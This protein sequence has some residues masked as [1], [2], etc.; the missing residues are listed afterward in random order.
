MAVDRARGW[1]ALRAR[2]RR[3]ALTLSVAARRIA[4][5]EWA[6]VA[7][8]VAGALLIAA[9]ASLVAVRIGAWALDETVIKQS[10]VHYTSGLPGTLFHDLNARGTSRLYSLVIAPL[11]AVFDGD[12]AVRAARV[13]N[14]L[15]FTSTAIPIFLLA[16]RAAA[17]R[18][19]SVAAGLL[20]VAAPWLILTTAIY[21]ENAAFPLFLW[22]VWA[23]ERAVRAPSARRDLLT[24][25]GITATTCART[26]FGILLVAYFVCVFAGPFAEARAHGRAAV[27]V[28]PVLWRR[29]I[30][31]HP[32]TLAVL[33]LSVVGLLYFA[34]RGRLH[35]EVQVV[36]G[37][38]SEIQDRT[39]ISSDMSL[40]L[41]VEAVALSIGIGVVPAIVAV[42]W[43]GRALRRGSGEIGLYA[44]VIAVFVVVFGVATVYAQGGYLGVHTE[45]RYYIYA[46]P[47]LWIGALA[48]L[49]QRG[50]VSARGL[51]A[52]G[53]VLALLF[54]TI[55]I[56]PHLDQDSQ[57]LGPV[58]ASMNHLLPQAI[59]HIGIAGLSPRDLL[60]AAGAVA[61]VIVA[62]AWPRATSAGRYVL[63]AAA[64]AVQ[65]GLTFY[66][67]EVARGNIFGVPGRTGGDFAALGWVDRALG[68]GG[69]ASW[70]NS[71]PRPDE[72][73]ADFQQRTVLFY[74]D[75]L[76]RT[77]HVPQLNVPQVNFPLSASPIADGTVDLRSGV[78]ALPPGYAGPVI[79]PTTSPLLQ[80]QGARRAS[81]GDLELVDAPPRA[82][83][84]WAALGLTAEGWV[85][86]AHPARFAAGARAGQRVRLA[87]TF[88]SSP[89]T[90]SGVVVRAGRAE[91]RLSFDAHPAAATVTLHL[92]ACNTSGRSVTGVIRGAGGVKAPT[93]VLAARLSAVRV[94][95]AGAC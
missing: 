22:T 71:Q 76:V 3:R 79:Q 77:V 56:E 9:A 41:L 45:E 81:G 26:Q 19:G 83:V 85:R 31:G 95:A 18:W 65:F 86:D 2:R 1:P 92:D 39:Q 89:G 63:V 10:A 38:Y 93:G 14:T 78:L 43:Y 60:F 42:D 7:A 6:P 52:A 51:W 11:F 69:H 72:F 46:M 80:I 21:T 44:F 20:S 25:V 35:H 33:A 61:A 23:G 57:F 91:R 24:L 62:L 53:G 94:T 47:F 28:T 30:R 32:W 66:I 55:P 4:A 88:V 27:D 54:A 84:R 82:P 48:A 75:D 34:M 67:F 5:A 12:V 50:S 8:L 40:G 15:L 58:L 36:F 49:R 59:G 17:G 73:A 70:L 68:N 16:R 37:S 90:A 29:L 13:L 64:V 74:N 87:L